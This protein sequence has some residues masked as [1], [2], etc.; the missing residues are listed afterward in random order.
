MS[1]KVENVSE[2]R[3][4]VRNECHFLNLSKYCNVLPTQ[5]FEKSVLLF[6]LAVS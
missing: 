3:K 5:V 6:S 1:K 2:R 4:N